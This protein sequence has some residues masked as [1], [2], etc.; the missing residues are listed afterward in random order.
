MDASAALTELDEKLVDAT[1]RFARMPGALW[2]AATAIVESATRLGDLSS[3]SAE[4]REDLLVRA[5]RARDEAG[6]RSSENDVSAITAWVELAEKRAALERVVQASLR[7]LTAHRQAHPRLGEA[8][9]TRKELERALGEREKEVTERAT[10]LAEPMPRA[11]EHSIRHMSGTGIP[12]PGDDDRSDA[13][14]QADA[15]AA[16]ARLDANAGWWHV[17]LV[18][19][20]TLALV[21]VVVPAFPSEI[22]RMGIGALLAVIGIG[23]AGWTFA[24][25]SARLR[26]DLFAAHA[27]RR[28]DVARR[29]AADRDLALVTQTAR[30]LGAVDAF[31]ATEDG[32]TLEDRES[33]LVTLAPWIRELLSGFSTDEA[34]RFA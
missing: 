8:P 22:G 25:G 23:V 30:A 27:M 24:R 5:R 15:R 2:L 12:P 4:R 33:K 32:R 18:I 6:P 10:R 17:P 9:K 29:E 26:R 14:L 7:E 31:G 16:R 34:S 20:I 21:A 1:T 28:R 19:G 13:A 3:A 11:E